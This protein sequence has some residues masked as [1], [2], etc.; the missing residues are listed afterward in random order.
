M[1]KKNRNHQ[2]NLNP[3]YGKRHSQETK[4]K[5]SDS[6]KSRYEQYKNA[7]NNHHATMDELLQSE[8]FNNRLRQIIREEAI[9]NDGEYK[10]GEG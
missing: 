8:S 2:G 7:M 1:E 3:M 6:Q 4:Q 5:I 10:V 9:K